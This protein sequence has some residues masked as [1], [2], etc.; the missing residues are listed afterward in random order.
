MQRAMESAVRLQ[1]Q[2]ENPNMNLNLA[3]KSVLVTGAS[4]GIGHAIAAAFAAEGAQVTMIARGAEEL[5][6][7]AADI[8]KAGGKTLAIAG[9]V[10]KDA[11]LKRIVEETVARFGT[12]HVL[13]NN[14][15]GA[16]GFNA[17][18]ESSD[19]E[20][21]ETFDL[22][23]FS[24]VRLTRAVLPIMRK[25][26]WGRIIN[27]SSESATQPD[28]QMPPYNA[29]KAA[30]NS[31]TKSLSKA[32]ALD[33]I[34]VNTVSPAF[35]ETPLITNWMEAQA[36]ARGITPEEALKEFM[37][38]FRPHIELKRPGRPEEVAGIVVFLA[39][40]EASFITG[41]NFRIDGGSV[42]SV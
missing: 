22:N 5:N 20:W 38:T 31:L 42:A 41:S 40:D 19:Q 33:G 30:L 13:V 25:Q 4:K 34:L 14:A 9:D 37:S 17:F 16:K 26:K 3:G 21:I 23:L 7:A 35:I 36:K 18:E 29:S 11:D 12:I 1:Y 39:S 15:G 28:A 8:R 32:V 10:T 24:V 27:I 6:R 2:T